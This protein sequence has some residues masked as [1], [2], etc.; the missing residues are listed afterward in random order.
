[1][2]GKVYANSAE[3]VV[4]NYFK[5]YYWDTGAWHLVDSTHTLSS[6]LSDGAGTTTNLSG[7]NV[8]ATKLRVQPG[9]VPNL[10]QFK[11]TINAEGADATPWYDAYFDVF[12]KSD[13][14][15][16]SVR[17]TNPVY[18][19]GETGTKTITAYVSCDGTQITTLAGL[20][21]RGATLK[22]LAYDGSGTAVTTLNGVTLSTIPNG[23]F[24][25][26]CLDTDVT[27]KATVWA[28]IEV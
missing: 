6:T 4:S 19:N 9:A 11:V 28:T 27:S 20:T 2:V 25:I 22:W 8:N 13:Q 12:D 18:K 17:C 23:T 10:R 7:T 24:T 21:N 3:D 15:Q 16:I 14:W 1:L 26:N 5:W